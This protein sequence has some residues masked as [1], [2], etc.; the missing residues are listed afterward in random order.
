MGVT[1][2][3]YRARIGAHNVKIKLDSTQLE[4][5]FCDT[6]LMLFQL[7]ITINYIDVNILPV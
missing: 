4:G 7:E 1:I 2:E 6:M 5:N 3:Q